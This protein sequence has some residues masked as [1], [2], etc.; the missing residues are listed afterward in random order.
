MAFTQ[1]ADGD[2]A[3]STQL[4]QVIDA[5]SGISGAGQP[6]SLTTLDDDGE[7]ALSVKNLGTGGLGLK[8]LSSA[9]ADLLEVR[10]SYTVI[11]NG[12]VKVDHTNNR[13]GINNTSPAVALDVTGTG[14]ISG[15]L[16]VGGDL[17]VGGSVSGI[18]VAGTINDGTV[19]LPGLRF[20]SDTN[21]GIRRVGTDQWATV[22]GGKDGVRHYLG[23]KGYVQY[24]LGKM[25]AADD[26]SWGA[27]NA[28]TI[29]HV[30]LNETS[31]SGGDT[32]G[33]VFSVTSVASSGGAGS[34]PDSSGISCFFQ[35]LSGTPN[36]SGRAVEA[37]AIRDTSTDSFVSADATIKGIEVGVH[38]RHNGS[39]TL[40]NKVVGVEILS[41]GS[42]LPS[43]AV[44]A[45]DA[46]TGVYIHGDPGF[47]RP[48][49]YLN[50]KSGAGANDA[51]YVNKQGRVYA[52]TGSATSPHYSFYG[53]TDTGIYDLSA[54]VLGF[55]TAGSEQMRLDSNGIASGGATVSGYRLMI[56]GNGRFWSNNASVTEKLELGRTATE[57][58]A[59]VSHTTSQLVTGDAAGD[60]VLTAATK[61]WLG[62]G[63]TGV[64]SAT[65]TGVV[66]PLAMAA[67]G[68]ITPTA[69]SATTDNW[70]PTGLS[71]ARIIRA[72]ASVASRDLTGITAQAS[73]TM[74]TIFNVGAGTNVVL[75]HATGSS[76][77]NQ[78]LTPNGVDVTISPSGSA[79]LWYDGT[80]SKWRVMD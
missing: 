15:S 47:K 51:F 71:T 36:G 79:S 17:T 53:D 45:T 24:G 67:T 20:S 57:L 13:V 33:A 63:T 42:S 41:S 32:N 7:F 4:Q 12:T 77:A 68:V 49:Y 39:D 80:S 76:S 34:I 50:E 11:D 44:N 55:A 1:V 38:T 10:D 9:G 19:S 64:M 16:A 48:I 6:I 69:L 74:L 3:V 60:G 21:N 43:G 8:V 31:A 70:N 66:F 46:D 23:T 75:K 61:L 18:S 22:A 25:D 27:V 58:T 30:Q 40:Y 52:G 29:M 73:G 59:G 37:Q 26:W 14:S 2:L 35:Q 78:I 54:N 5:L 72:E 62:V 28:G 65:T 56:Y